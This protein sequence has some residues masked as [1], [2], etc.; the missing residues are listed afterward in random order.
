MSYS[1]LRVS[2]ARVRV[3]NRFPTLENS[4]RGFHPEVQFRHGAERRFWKT[5]EVDDEYTLRCLEQ[6]GIIAVVY[7]VI[8]PST[9]AKCSFGARGLG[10]GAFPSRTIVRVPETCYIVRS[11]QNFIRR[12]VSCL[13]FQSLSPGRYTRR[14]TRCVL[15]SFDRTKNVFFSS[16]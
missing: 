15:A 10:G 13:V 12:R 4:A 16:L 1:V 9:L 11:R 7:T 8:C 5:T 6:I 2:C 3:S 14:H